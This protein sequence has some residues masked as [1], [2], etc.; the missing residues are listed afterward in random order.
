M[1]NFKTLGIILLVVGIIIIASSLLID[2]LGF[3]GSPN[4]GSK[5]ITGLIVG[6]VTGVVG[7]FLIR[8]K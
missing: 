7:L 8:K 3:G 1:K 6:V 5:Q 2:I 4:F